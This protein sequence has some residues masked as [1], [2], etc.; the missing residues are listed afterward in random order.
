MSAAGEEKKLEEYGRQVY[1]DSTKLIREA[2]PKLVLHIGVA[3]LVWLFGNLVFI[4]VSVGLFV[5]EYA[6]TQIISLITLVAIAGLIA[7]VLYEARR[8]TDAA[9]GILA[10]EIGRRGEVDAEE[11]SHYRTALR[12]LLYVVIVALAFLFFSAN[13]STIH[14]ALAGVALIVVVIWAFF[15]LWRVGRALSAELSRYA[16]E[17]AKRLEK[18]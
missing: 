7:A 8:V 17:W 1:V 2:G 6:V 18:R 12:G 9:A 10:Y 13:L 3:V 4:P 11:V 15:T 16:D 14:P 5:R